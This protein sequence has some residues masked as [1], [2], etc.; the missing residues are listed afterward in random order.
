MFLGK[1]EVNVRMHRSEQLKYLVIYNQ[2]FMDYGYDNDN[3]DGI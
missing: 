2:S 1:L 3:D